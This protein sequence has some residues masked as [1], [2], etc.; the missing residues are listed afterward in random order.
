M[1]G[2]HDAPSM[3]ALIEAVREWIAADVVDASEGRLR[4]H[5]RVAAN[6][7]GMVERELEFGE[8][9]AAAHRD[10]LDALGV[11][12]DAELSR[13]IRSGDFDDRAAELR[14]QLRV[15]IVDKLRVANPAYLEPADREGASTPTETG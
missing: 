2:P 4:F 12:D 5:A 7:L 1:S 6:M 11:A 8:A 10:R 15:S 9:Q 3:A 13:R 14:A